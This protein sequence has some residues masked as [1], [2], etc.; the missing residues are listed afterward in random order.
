MVEP[1]R[2]R[3]LFGAAQ[4][5]EL[6]RDTGK[7]RALYISLSLTRDHFSISTLPASSSGL[8]SHV[9]NLATDSVFALRVR[10][11]PKRSLADHQ[12]KGAASRPLLLS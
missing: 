4:A 8:D 3:S 10:K 6:S 1:N 9:V 7:A 12:K 2:F 5:A 11:L